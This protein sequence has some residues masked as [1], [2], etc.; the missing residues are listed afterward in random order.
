MTTSANPQPPNSRSLA[1]QTWKQG[2][3]VNYVVPAGSFIDPQH[4][5]LTYTATRDNGSPLPL[6]L[7]FNAKTHVFTGTPPAGDGF[8]VMVTATNSDGLSASQTFGVTLI[9][10]P[11]VQS[12]GAVPPQIWLPG[13]SIDIALPDGT[14]TDPQGENLIYSA[15]LSTGGALPPWLHVDKTSGEITGTVSPYVTSMKIVE[16]ATDTSGLSASFTFGVTGIRAPLVTRHE[17][18]QTITQ[19]KT[20]HLSLSGEFTDPQHQTLSYTVTQSDGSALP[21]WMSFNASTDVLSG[22]APATAGK[23]GIVVSATDPVGLTVTDKFTVTTVA[24]PVLNDQT[25]NQTFLAGK[26]N[27]FSLA[28]DTFVDPNGQHLTY[29]ASQGN[30]AALPTWLHFN[31]ATE[32]ISGTPKVGNLTLAAIEA[33]A[34]ADWAKIA[35][36]PLTVEVT[37][38]DSSGL[39]AHETFTLSFT[40]VPL[41]G[42]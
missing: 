16:T 25:A 19:G 20:L 32:T 10:S 3:A 34:P 35:P 22:V 21:S 24:A 39:T 1:D 12:A 13:Q 29:S 15:R 17:T 36:K 18:N 30:G 6:W 26:N 14:F 33:L 8:G 42:V 27:S 37:A 40:N 23:I 38:H 9:D 5:T 4:E 28:S 11:V 2:K 41:V 7:K 31:S